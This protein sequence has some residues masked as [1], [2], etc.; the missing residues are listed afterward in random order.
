MIV[1]GSSLSP[2]ARKALAFAAEK[3][4]A[5][6][7]VP[8]NPREPMPEFLEASPFGKMPALRDGDFTISDSS[9]IVHYLEAK[10]PEPALIPAEPEARARTIWFEEFA[11]TMLVPATAKIF[12]NRFL[13]P[14]LF[15][16]EGDLAAAEEAET[17]EL[18]PL[19]DYLEKQ[20]AHADH[21]VGNRLTLADVAVA[22][23]VA[24]LA[25]IG[26][27]V[28]AARH[29]R[30]AAF[31]ARIFARESFAKLMNEEAQMVASMG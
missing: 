9:A 27:G 15:G 28:D 20:L 13:R 6:D 17:Q 29:P 22:S 12:L 16:Q 7:N 2:Y 26:R 21:L 11:D 1:Y 30:T 5:I 3:G 14:R 18:P 25:A 10:H 24:T 31:C 23:P 19:F 4:I 8:V